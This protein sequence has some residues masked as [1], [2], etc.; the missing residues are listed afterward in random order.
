MADWRQRRNGTALVTAVR[1]SF[2][3][4]LFNNK[5]NP[6]RGSGRVDP[7]DCFGGLAS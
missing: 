4:L 1:F 2:K 3:A 6:S 5:G 7:G